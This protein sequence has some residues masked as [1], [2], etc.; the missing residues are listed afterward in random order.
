MKRTDKD[1]ATDVKVET[2]FEKRLSSM[3]KKVLHTPPKRT[4]GKKSQ[5]PP[6]QRSG[7]KSR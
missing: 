7:S 5:Q 6:N 1:K 4:A 2:G 3:Y